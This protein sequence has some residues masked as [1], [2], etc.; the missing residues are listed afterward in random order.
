M[1]LGRHPPAERHA[2]LFTL[3]VVVV[4]VVHAGMSGWIAYHISPAW[5]EVGHLPAGMYLC[6]FGRFDVYRV[7]PPL[8]R[9]LA[10]L[11]VALSSPKTDWRPYAIGPSA[12][13]EWSLG[14]S[15]VRANDH[16]NGSWRWFFV[17]ARWALIPFSVVGAC[18]CYRWA[19]D[20]YGP[21]SGLL[22]TALWCFSPNVLAWSSTICPDAAAAAMGVAACYSFWRW[23]RNPASSAALAAGLL[24]GLAQLTK[25]TWIVLFPLWPILWIVVALAKSQGEQ[26]RIGS[27]PEGQ[28]AGSVRPGRTRDHAKRTWSRQ[29][30][31]MAAILALGVYVIN[32][33]YL[34]EDS[35]ARLGDY[36][37]VSRTLAGKESLV[38]GGGGGNRFQG[39]WLAELP[40]PVP[41]NYLSGI[42]LQKRDFEEGKWSYLRGRWKHGG[43]W[44]YYLYAALLKVP[45]GTWTLGLLAIVLT[46]GVRGRSQSGSCTS[47]SEGGSNG[48]W[49]G[50]RNE[51]VLLAPALVVF[52]LV[53]SQTGFSRYFRYV[54]PC[55]PFVFIWIS[56]VARSMRFKHRVAAWVAGGAFLWSVGSSLWYY[57]HSM[58]YFNEL[59][60]GPT[61]GHVHLIDANID[62]GQDMWR[63]KR[64]LEE[65]P[66]AGPLHMASRSLIP[67]EHFGI[68]CKRPPGGPQ[69]D[70]HYADREADAVGPLPGWYAMSIHRIHDATENYLYFLRLRPL[71]R[72]G[73]SIYIYH[74]TLDE[75]NRVRRELGLPEV[76]GIE[77]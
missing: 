58:S 72:A 68:D 76:K 6:E 67:A 18:V 34:F 26:E 28:D 57:P 12:R 24:L 52:V 69:P 64:W 73:Y 74:I 27:V 29:A 17:I 46:I 63:L 21:A 42:D 25:M 15:F 3:V 44:Y 7:N 53:S 39:T 56:K 32:L 62:W 9:A 54:L 59:A 10:A 77:G 36:T 5:D 41:Q 51:F 20:L 43:W 55:F 49:A 48:Y 19:R 23:L 60:K 38:A 35:F 66:E 8:V 61:G 47:G 11:P 71:A 2:R 13:P 14:R 4:L 70:V 16:G 30:V 37:F 50:W 40:V 31:Q 33:G 22:A 65:H 75:A 1:A 45:L